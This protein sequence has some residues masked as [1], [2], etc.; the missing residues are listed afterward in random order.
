MCRIRPKALDSSTE[1]D[2]LATL[3]VFS[4]FHISIQVKWISWSLPPEGSLKLN[5]DG[6]SKG[7]PGLSGRG[8]VLRNHRGKFVLA[9]SY[10]NGVCT[11]MEAELRA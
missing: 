9:G 3:N 7:N 6:S 4:P 11:N 2:M 8:A 10:F 1:K 5:I